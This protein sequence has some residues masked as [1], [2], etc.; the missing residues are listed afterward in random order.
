MTLTANQAAAHSHSLSASTVAAGDTSPAGNVTA[1]SGSSNI[2]GSAVGT[3]MNSGA[4]GNTGRSTGSHLH[5]EV[6]EDGKA[7]DPLYFILDR[8]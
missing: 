2:Y 6:H 4:I 1:T 8:F 5:Y 7:K 3:A